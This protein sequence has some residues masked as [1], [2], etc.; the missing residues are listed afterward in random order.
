LRCR[1]VIGW[2]AGGE[3]G[4]TDDG[5][6]DDAS[7]DGGDR[8]PWSRTGEL[9]TGEDGPSDGEGDAGEIGPVGA[10]GEEGPADEPGEEHGPPAGAEIGAGEAATGR[11]LAGW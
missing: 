5:A 1:V 11:A 4:G 3:A 6:D 9:A 2:G 10:P 7:A 8:P